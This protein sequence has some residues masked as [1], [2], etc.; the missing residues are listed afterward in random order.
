MDPNHGSGNFSI[1]STYNGS[2]SVLVPVR[3]YSRNSLLGALH[4]KSSRWLG[5]DLNRY[6]LTFHKQKDAN[7]TSIK[8]EEIPFHKL[9]GLEADVSAADK[10]KFYMTV[11]T[12][13]GDL[14]FK[15]KSQRDFHRVMEALRYTLHSNKPLYTASEK[16]ELARTTS[17]YEKTFE[18]LDTDG[19]VSSDELEDYILDTKYTNP[20]TTQKGE[21]L[22]QKEHLVNTQ[23]QPH[24]ISQQN[25]NPEGVLRETKHDIKYYAEED[26]PQADMRVVNDPNNP[27]S[28]N[29]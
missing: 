28:G 11:K 13:E 9:T 3:M 5:V 25:K 15:F 1:N 24:H 29:Q 6:I 4:I 18:R 26:T 27:Y 22:V 12:Q 21:N 10:D 17:N 16:Y 2:R 20:S 23:H 14:K 8:S 19:S 7:Y